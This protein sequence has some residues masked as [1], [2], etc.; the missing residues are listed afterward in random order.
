MLNRLKKVFKNSKNTFICKWIGKFMSKIIKIVAFEAVFLL[1]AIIAE[2][3]IL[4]QPASTNIYG[5]ILDAD[6]LQ[7]IPN[8]NVYVRHGYGTASSINGYFEIPCHL[9]DTIIYSCVG[10]QMVAFA[11][12]D[13]L[14]GR[15]RVVGIVMQTDTV[16]IQEVVVLPFITYERL[17]Y[18][19]ANMQPDENISLAIS[20]IEDA[21]SLALSEP[22]PQ[23]D[24][25]LAPM[26]QLSQYTERLE[27][28][29]MVA[30]SNM[31]SII[32]TNS[33]AIRYIRKNDWMK[34]RQVTTNHQKQLQ[35][36]KDV[37]N[38]VMK[39]NNGDE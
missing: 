23:L 16:R 29:G 37:R 28:A 36:A 12:P 21:V 14:I 10:Y 5:S 11:V 4:S 1:L 18:E 2:G 34:A 15:S 20:N 17:K 31:F 33:G 8:V 19:V 39:K 7:P 3:Q 24:A 25:E 27:Y 6:D 32:G 38:F 9:G 22:H 35:M 26:R 30:P 13:S